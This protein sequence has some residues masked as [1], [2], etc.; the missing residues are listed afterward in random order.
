M[1]PSVQ[2]TLNQLKEIIDNNKKTDRGAREVQKQCHGEEVLNPVS[3]S[4]V[5]NTFSIKSMINVNKSVLMRNSG[6]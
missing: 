5:W 3:R 4:L 2:Q 6:C 1:S